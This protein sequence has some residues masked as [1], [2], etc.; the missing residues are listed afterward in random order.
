MKFVIISNLLELCF[1]G[2]KYPPWDYNDLDIMDTSKDV[3]MQ[4]IFWK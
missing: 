4:K 1:S 2:I 3:V